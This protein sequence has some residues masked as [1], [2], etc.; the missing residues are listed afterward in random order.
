MIYILAVL[1]LSGQIKIERSWEISLKGGMHAYCA[2]GPTSV[3][4]AAPL[5]LGV[6]LVG[7]PAILRRPQTRLK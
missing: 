6:A 3:Q 5:F 4:S 2:Q 7:S 1:T